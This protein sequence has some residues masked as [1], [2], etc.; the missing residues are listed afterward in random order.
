MHLPWLLL[1]LASGLACPGCDEGAPAGAPSLPPGPDGPGGRYFTGPMFFDRVV[2]DAPVSPASSTW[3][4]GLRAAGGWGGGDRL[5]ID[6]S[7]T[8]LVADASTP[9]RTFEKAAPYFYEPDCDHAPVPLPAGGNLEG[10][11]GYACERQGDCHLIVHDPA[12]GELHELWKADLAGTVLSGGCLAVW[13]AGRTYAEVLRGDQCASADGAGFPIAPLLFTADEV[14]AGVIPHAIRF[15]LPNDRIQRAFVRP[16]THGTETTGAPD[17][18]PYGVHLRLRADYPLDTLPGPGAVVVAR[19]LQT[20]GMYLADG[21]DIALTAQ[22]DITGG[23]GGARWAGLLDANALARL[24]VEDFEVVDH[25][26]PLALTFHCD[27][28]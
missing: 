3:I 5:L 4:A 7:L 18:P 19:A 8:V 28:S 23:T 10:E 11:D 14:A 16:A 21:G 22:A 6:T 15:V 12:R 13:H 9:R 24:R 20:Y 17:A 2:T 26:E 27:R 25:G 1:V